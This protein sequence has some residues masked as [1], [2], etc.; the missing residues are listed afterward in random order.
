MV[1]T[2]HIQYSPTTKEKLLA[3]RL[4][5]RTRTRDESVLAW[6]TRNTGRL[7]LPVHAHYI[8]MQLI[9]VCYKKQ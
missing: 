3:T 9:F 6:T 4:S 8:H 2:K 1:I 5:R 7:K